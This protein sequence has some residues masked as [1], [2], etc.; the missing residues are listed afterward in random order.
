VVVDIRETRGDN[1][2]TGD[3]GRWTV[4]VVHGAVYRQILVVRLIMAVLWSCPNQTGDP[5]LRVD[6]VIYWSIRL[7]AYFLVRRRSQNRVTVLE[8]AC[9]KHHILRML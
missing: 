2:E 6:P 4:D 8:Y 9:C 7:S 5:N 1:G 3:G